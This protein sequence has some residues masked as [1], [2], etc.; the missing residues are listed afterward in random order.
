MAKIMYSDKL[1]F[2]GQPLPVHLGSDRQIY[3][4]LNDIC[5]FIGVAPDGMAERIQQDSSIADVLVFMPLLGADTDLS[6]QDVSQAAFLNLAALS[7][8]L[9]KISSESLA[10]PDL[11]DALVRYTFEFLD[12][13]WMLY[14]AAVHELEG[15]GIGRTRIGVRGNRKRPPAARP[16]Y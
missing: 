7:Y 15:S 4:L 16:R 12:T 8:W 10:H 13:T 5:A 2:N 3:V 1:D 9:G 6:A 14:K 11:H